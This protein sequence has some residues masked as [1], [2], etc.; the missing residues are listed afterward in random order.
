LH[1]DIINA[2]TKDNGTTAAFLEVKATYDIVL[3]FILDEKL[4]NVGVPPNLRALVWQL[5]SKRVLHFKFGALDEIRVRH[6]GLPQGNMLSPIM[7]IIFTA[8]LGDILPPGCRII[9][10]ADDVCL[11]SSVAPLEAAT[12]ITKEGLNKVG[13]ALQTLGLEISPQ[14][15][16]LM[17]FSPNNQDCYQKN[18][19]ERGKRTVTTAGPLKRETMLFLIRKRL[20]L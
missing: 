2:F 19:G 10:L 9:E 12:R 20:N 11:F 4:K 7:C 1:R 8:Q 18:E 15:T 3:P 16:K 5:G 17:V 14:K 6:R 13:E